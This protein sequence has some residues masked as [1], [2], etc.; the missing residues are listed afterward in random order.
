LPRAILEGGCDVPDGSIIGEDPLLDA[1]RFEMSP[2]GVVLVTR[3]R[4]ARNHAEAR[5]PRRLSTPAL[6]ATQPE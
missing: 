5:A 1:E 3:D 6:H 2:G 4:L